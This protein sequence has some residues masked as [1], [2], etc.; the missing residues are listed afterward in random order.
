MKFVS[1]SN[2]EKI[3]LFA[4]MIKASFFSRFFLLVDE[5]ILYT[6]YYMWIVIKKSF[7]Y[8]YKYRESGEE[9]IIKF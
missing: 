4:M 7:I 9:N 5:F 3:I 1:T 8:K 2:H 6:M